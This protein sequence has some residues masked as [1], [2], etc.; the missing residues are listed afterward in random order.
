MWCKVC[1]QDAPG[2]RLHG[3]GQLCCAHC[4]TALPGPGEPTVACSD[5]DS[6]VACGEDSVA[7]EE[8]RSQTPRYDSWE[9]GER[10]RHIERVLH[11]EATGA[12][13]LPVTPSQGVVRARI[14]AAEDSPRGWHAGAPLRDSRTERRGGFRRADSVAQRPAAWADVVLSIGIWLA[15]ALGIT[16]LVCGGILLAW[17][18]LDK[19]PEL[20]SIGLPIAI[21]G[22]V[23]LL[24]ALVLQLDRTWRNHHNTAAKL[25]DFEGQIDDLRSAAALLTT[26]H[27]SP[28]TAFYAHYCGGASP[29]VLLTDLKSQLD[30]LAIKIG[31]GDGGR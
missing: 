24:L 8:P 1:Q 13:R 31:N 9:T 29:T 4:G 30:L 17:S 7:T 18:A 25:D 28:A 3:R 19:R 27:S 21:V 22:Q 14:D 5:I 11:G 12:T 6:P 23:A 20:W 10:L 16:T 26:T 15:L 2:I